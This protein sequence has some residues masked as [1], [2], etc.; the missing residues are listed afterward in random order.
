M[1]NWNKEALK[2]FFKTKAAYVL[3]AIFVAASATLAIWRYNT[4]L[5]DSTGHHGQYA[6]TFF[7]TAAEFDYASGVQAIHLNFSQPVDP[8][9]ITDYFTL[10]PNMAG[11]FE[12][13]L[14]ING[15]DTYYIPEYPFQSGTDYTITLKT[16]LKSKLGSELT[17]DYIKILSLRFTADDFKILKND[18]YALLQSVSLYES[19]VLRSQIGSNIK[20]PSI[21]IFK[22]SDPE[23]AI[24]DII[25]YA[26]P[27]YGYQQPGF[28]TDTKKLT[29][30]DAPTEVKHNDTI[31]LPK[32]TGIYL[33]QAINDNQVKSQTWVTVN[34]MGVHFRQDDK[35]FIVAAQDLRSGEPLQNI[36]LKTYDVN[37][38]KELTFLQKQQVNGLGS[39]PL[40]YPNR[41]GVMTAKKGSEF[42][43]IPVSINGSLAEINVYQNLAN[44]WQGF[45][46]TD[47]PI[48]KTTDTVKFRGIVRQDNDGNYTLPEAGSK[49][50]LRTNGNDNPGNLQEVEATINEH[51]V[52][53]G[54]LP[55][56]KLPAGIYSMYGEM[57]GKIND[58]YLAGINAWFEIRDY[59]KPDFELKTQI[60]KEEA[61][62]GD[63]INVTLSGS[64]FDGKAFGKQTVTYTVY[65]MDFYETEKS[66]YNKSFN[67]NGW[68]GM[69]G[70][71]GDGYGENY[72]GEP[73][74][75]AKEVTTNASGTFSTSFDTRKLTRNVSK[76]ITF[77]AEKQD[78]NGN[79]I[80]D[81]KTAIVHNGDINI[82]LRS[83]KSQ[84][85][86]ADAPTAVFT[87]ETQSGD[88]LKNQSFDYVIDQIKYEQG[89]D[90]KQATPL[91]S[92]K[93]KTNNDGVGEFKVQ[94]LDKLTGEADTIEVSVRKK[95]SHGNLVTGSQTLYAYGNSYQFERPVL[96]DVSSDQINLTPGEE[97]RLK[98]ISPGN[99][100]VMLAFE[101]GRVYDPQ[102]LDLKTGENTYKFIV[103]DSYMPSITPTFTA[104]YKNH[105]YSEGLSFNVP[106]MKKLVNINVTTDKQVYSPGQ[107]AKVS[108][109]VTD[110]NGKPVQTDLSLGIIDKAIFALRKSTQLPLHSSFYFFRDRRTNNSSSMTGISFGEGSERGG[111][112]GD[113]TSFSAKDVDVLYWNPELKTNSS[114]EL[115]VFVNVVGTTAWKGVIYAA[116]DQTLL[117]QTDFE[118]SSR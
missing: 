118:F 57:T 50:L 17:E 108:I 15:T 12:K 25:S 47:R 77:V 32:E 70:G 42:A 107:V 82:F 38:N 106:A 72:Y 112:G 96:L 83:F 49:I 84:S 2:E 37:E 13:G 24:R 80:T 73:I 56:K 113:D 116:N 27:A 9:A 97:A 29:S 91:A 101:R 18:R 92:G 22:A 63:K 19:S 23:I 44:S 88:K 16:G 58:G 95:D 98:I 78:K 36:E 51:G 114:G 117:G 41:I 87:A 66:V 46:Y 76:Q 53:F 45:L 71:G 8:S 3:L 6:E 39:F 89:S 43:I 40:G 5:E 111:G 54:E 102:W 28:D 94:G 69:C 4:Q 93:V 10:T 104:F 67:L 33:I 115:T 85:K 68:G 59:T 26:S 7:V 30:I 55:L 21:K 34:T 1:F 14:D 52:F 31:N 81:T 60:D 99:M 110:Q 79:K 90:K 48:Y 11:R 105:Y 86:S 65:G 100:K 75:S 109:K 61:T 20:N 74:E 103:P 62:E 35:K 64:R